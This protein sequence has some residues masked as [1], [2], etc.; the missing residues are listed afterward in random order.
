MASSKLHNH[1]VSL[2]VTFC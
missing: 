2:L 1:V